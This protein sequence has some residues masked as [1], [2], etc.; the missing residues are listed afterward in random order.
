MTE[1]PS[2]CLAICS[3]DLN[4]EYCIGCGRTL[5][6]IAGWLNASEAER[7]AIVEQLPER[8]IELAS[9]AKA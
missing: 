6:E 8:L 7:R 1:T 3:L 9:S 5:D 2:P 4:D